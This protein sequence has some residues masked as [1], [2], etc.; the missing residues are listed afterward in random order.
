M[1]LGSKHCYLSRIAPVS[2][3]LFRQQKEF[4]GK[5]K[6]IVNR[7]MR[8]IGGRQPQPQGFCNCSFT[9]CD[10]SVGTLTSASID[11]A[12]TCLNVLHNGIDA[13]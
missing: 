4:A 12:R 1:S 8:T 7:G 10:R 5:N 2:L 13:M 9:L 11:H 3:A 6:R